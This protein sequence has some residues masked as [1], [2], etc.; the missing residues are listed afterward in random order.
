VGRFGE[1]RT[2]VDQAPP[3]TWEAERVVYL[4]NGRTRFDLRRA[5]E[6]FGTFET[7]LSGSYN[8]GNV[9]AAIAV[10]TS[11][12]VQIDVVRR[13]VAS[14]FG[15]TRR[16]EFR[17][18]ANGVT[19]IDDYAHHP[20]AVARTL[21]GLRRRYR[22]RRLIALYEP[23]SATSRRAIFQKQYAQA[24]HHADVVVVGTL[25]Q[26]D[27]I[28]ARERFDPERLAREL[29][30]AGTKA[31]Y[32]PEVDAIVAHVVELARPGDVVVVLS[33]GAFGGIHEKLVHELGDAVIPARPEDVPAI[34]ELLDAQGL[35]PPSDDGY[36]DYFVCL[37]ETGFVG[38]V[39]IVIYG[40]DSVLCS[41]AV[42]PAARGQG[43]GW[44]LADVAINQA[45]WRG[46]R[47]IYLITESASDFFAAKFG[48]RIVDRSTLSKQVS[49]HE[50]FARPIATTTLGGTQLVA[51]RLDL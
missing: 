27:K 28:A 51:M 21:L 16:Q 39:A 42:K 6:P 26:P 33:S 11:V 41:L 15:V 2:L 1:P 10:T 9:V 37:N 49:A 20:T 17:G 46:V 30:Q 24:F 45:R 40:E 48:F 31:S 36:R 5:G 44:M 34:R 32:I 19:L 38:C 47:R 43:Y 12:G 14:Y 22:G 50:T 18:V 7:I 25:H 23:R 4:K 35:Q 29:H 13:A 3:A 8:L